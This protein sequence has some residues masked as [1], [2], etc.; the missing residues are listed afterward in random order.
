MEK[1]RSHPVIQWSYFG[2]RLA[3]FTGYFGVSKRRCGPHGMRHHWLSQQYSPTESPL[4]S[5]LADIQLVLEPSAAPANV[6]P[7]PAPSATPADS[8]SE[9]TLATPANALPEPQSASYPDTQPE[10]QSVAPA[11]SQPDLQSAVSANPQPDL[12]EHQLAVLTNT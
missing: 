11:N 2:T 9:P 6:Q 10:V 4:P 12:L 3:V 5:T 8:L 1:P 7:V